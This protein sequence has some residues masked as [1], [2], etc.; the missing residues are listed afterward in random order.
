MKYIKANSILPSHLIKELQKYIQSGY[1]Y[2]P[3]KK[4]DKKEWGELSGAKEK[5]KK[6]NIDIK[7]KHKAGK[8]IEE[9]SIEF[10]L[11]EHTIIKIIYSK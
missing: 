7:N 4:E 5:I 9:L 1:I 2:I 3:S 10:F 6:R 8:T 11:S